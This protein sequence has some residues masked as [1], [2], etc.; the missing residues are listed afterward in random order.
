MKGIIYI[1]KNNINGKVYIGQTIQK[2]KDRWYRHCGKSGL[3][4]N[5]L[6][7]HIKRAILKYGKENF[8]IEVLEEC[9]Q[10]DLN[11]REKYYIKKYDSYNSGY[12]HTKGGQDGSQPSFRKIPEEKHVEVI[13]LYNSGLS[14]R[15]IADDYNV[16]KHTIKHILTHYNVDVRNTRSYKYSKK[17]REEILTDYNAGL[18]RK[19][20]VN[21]WK[22][23]ISYLSQ[24]INGIRNV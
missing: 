12:N 4:K 21:K 1:I 3:S 20:I 7:M 23:S 18:S 24:L 5:E 15:C 16:D 14:L 11:E 8:T 10:C 22:I 2:L 13:E 19:E 17:E 9:N 6:N